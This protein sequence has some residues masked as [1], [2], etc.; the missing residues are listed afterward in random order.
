MALVLALYLALLAPQATPPPNTPPKSE[1]SAG[2]SA[3]AP[4]G[5]HLAADCQ[6]PSISY[7]IEP[8]F[9]LE[10]RKA[11]VLG[12]VL[13]ALVVDA[14]GNP[15]NA[16]VLKSLASTVKKS[17]QSAALTLDQRAV[18][19]VKQYRF[20]PAI[21]NGKSVAVQLNVEVDFQIIK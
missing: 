9:T 12:K 10:A 19:A 13:V 6:P 11:K 4:S 5:N 16:H 7:Q 20:K 15:A 1:P 21:C 17:Q 18:D 3:P 14:Q 8:E 2:L